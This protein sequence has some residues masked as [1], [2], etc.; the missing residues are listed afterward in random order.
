MALSD[1]GGGVKEWLCVYFAVYRELIVGGKH[2][3]SQYR[4]SLKGQNMTVSSPYS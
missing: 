2:L 1:N 4:S 3:K